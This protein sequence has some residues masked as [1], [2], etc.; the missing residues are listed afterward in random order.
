MKKYTM[1]T[2]VGIFV[3][4]GLACVA[5]MTVRLGH[6]S[7]WGE[8]SYPLYAGF[9]DISGLKVGAPVDIYGIKVGQVTK[10]ILNQ[11]DQMAILKL[12]IKKGIEIYDDAMASVRTEG[13]IGDEYISISPGGAGSLLKPGDSIVDTQPAVN[14]YDLLGKYIFGGVNKP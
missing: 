12:S 1:E 11:K 7:P 14:I 6:V 2:I 8:N 13:L 5:Y 9:S 4:V 3:V 10:I